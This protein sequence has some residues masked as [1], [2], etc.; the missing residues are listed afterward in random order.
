VSFAPFVV[1]KSLVELGIPAHR[2]AEKF[3]PGRKF[4]NIVLRRARSLESKASDTFRGL[5][6]LR[7]E[8][9]FPPT[10]AM[11][12]PQETQKLAGAT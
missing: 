1:S 5:G 7:G 9:S 10:R 2:Q 12:D 6:D 11:T 3:A 4:K 8:N